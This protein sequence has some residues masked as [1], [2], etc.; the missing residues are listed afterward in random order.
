MPYKY[1]IDT[2][3]LS[4]YYKN[5]I[6]LPIEVFSFGCISVI[7]KIELYNWLDN[8]RIDTVK[9]KKILKSIQGL[10]VIHFNEKISKLIEQ[11]ADKNLNSKPADTIIGVS[12]IYHNLE[13][14]TG[15]KHDFDCFTGMRKVYYPQKKTK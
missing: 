9:R 5:E 12:A 3:V 14:H 4:R 6:K 11:H 8:Y 15:D 10:K 7:T 2:G 1:L 13:L